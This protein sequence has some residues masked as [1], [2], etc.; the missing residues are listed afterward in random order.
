MDR[1][2]DASS[3]KRCL[4]TVSGYVC[5]QEDLL[6]QVLIVCFAS[7]IISAV[8]ATVVIGY[9]LYHG[10][11]TSLYRRLDDYW[12][13]KPVDALLIGWFIEKILRAAAYGIIFIYGT[14]SLM[15]YEII[16]L[17]ATVLARIT[18]L[19]FVIGIIIHIPSAFSRRAT[20]SKTISLHTDYLLYIP[21]IR[22]IYIGN[23]IY[24]TVWFVFTLAIGIV[25]VVD[26]VNGRNP[27]TGQNNAILSAA[28]FI[29]Y[30]FMLCICGYYCY[31]FYRIIRAH[32][33]C[34]PKSD[35]VQEKEKRTARNFRNI[36]L[37]VLCL[38]LA[39]ILLSIMK[40]FLTLYPHKFEW[41]DLGDMLLRQVL[42]Y[43]LVECIV[44]AF[45]LRSSCNQMTGKKTMSG[46]SHIPLSN[47]NTISSNINRRKDASRCEEQAIDAQ[48]KPVPFATSN[49]SHNTSAWQSNST[50]ANSAALNNSSYEIRGSTTN[51][52]TFVERH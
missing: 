4:V 32:T 33:L 36:F 26:T 24:T 39:N 7:V 1:S 44:F 31:G 23:I 50:G 21:S 52:I 9:R 14:S 15:A 2:G 28:S 27:F 22:S 42:I 18:I 13:P 38:P 43:S 5:A 17:L 45:I 51:S 29:N 40:H 41:I 16:Y 25:V 46:S 10:L 37:A 47:P 48:F 30:L 34:I 19:Q 11:L 12:M 49:G 6:H 3:N 8:L 35:D 20:S